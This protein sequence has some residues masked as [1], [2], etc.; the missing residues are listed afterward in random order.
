MKC[1]SCKEAEMTEDILDLTK[2][3]DL[4]EVTWKC[5]KCETVFFGTLYREEK[6]GDS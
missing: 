6:G 4:I 5:P 3:V 1:P 2:D